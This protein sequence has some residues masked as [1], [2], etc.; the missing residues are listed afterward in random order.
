LAAEKVEARK[1]EVLGDSTVV[2]MQSTIARYKIWDIWPFADRVCVDHM[3]SLM[4]I[5][6]I[7]Q[8]I[9]ASPSGKMGDV[10]DNERDV[11]TVGSVSKPEVVLKIPTCLSSFMGRLPRFEGTEGPVPDPQR[12]L[13]ALIK[14]D[15][16]PSA[17]HARCSVKMPA[18]RISIPNNHGSFQGESIVGQWTTR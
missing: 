9:A 18:I 15:L 5:Q 17:I 16:S 1:R 14:T 11:R 10:F 4:G 3:K 7:Q 2:N 8:P 13:Q 12:P 6:T